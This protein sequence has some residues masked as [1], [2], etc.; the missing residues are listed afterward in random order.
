MAFQAQIYLCILIDL[1]YGLRAGRRGEG[2]GGLAFPLGRIS[3]TCFPGV[4]C[5]TLPFMYVGCVYSKENVWISSI[6]TPLKHLSI[7]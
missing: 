1:L 7:V 4:H 6:L 2:E 3:P 5:M